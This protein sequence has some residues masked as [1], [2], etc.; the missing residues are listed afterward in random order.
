MKKS[1]KNVMSLAQNRKFLSCHLTL[2]PPE[3][4]KMELLPKIPIYYPATRQ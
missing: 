2:Y 3:S 4:I 1:L